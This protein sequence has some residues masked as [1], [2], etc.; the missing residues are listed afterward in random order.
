MSIQ[1]GDWVEFPVNSGNK[2]LVVGV[3]EEGWCTEPPNLV[4][5]H[6]GA[7]G[8]VY[9]GVIQTQHARKFVTSRRT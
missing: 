5:A 9:E 8:K 1:I 2:H 3:D 4:I 7:R 6:K